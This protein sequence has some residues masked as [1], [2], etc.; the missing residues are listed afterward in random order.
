MAA[1]LFESA[2]ANEVRRVS[3]KDETIMSGLSCGEPSGMAWQI[4]SEE[5]SDFLTIPDKIVAPTVRVLA[6]PNGDDP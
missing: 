1:C 5:T 3:I 6:R 4:I 2:K